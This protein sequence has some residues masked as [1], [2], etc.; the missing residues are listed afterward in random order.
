MESGAIGGACDLHWC[1]RIEWDE[2]SD[3]GLVL[4]HVLGGTVTP[5]DLGGGRSQI[6]DLDLNLPDGRS[7]AVEV[8]RH[9]SE[10]YQARHG[11]AER[12]EWHFADLR[13]DWHVGMVQ[14]F[15]V[16]DINRYLPGLLRR[17]EQEE[18]EAVLVPRELKD[19]PSE[20]LEELHALG[21]RITYRLG[22]ADQRGGQIYLGEAP[23]AGVTAA[24][25]VVDVASSH[26][27]LADNQAKLKAATDADERHLFI[28]VGA[29]STQ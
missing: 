5:R 13:F 28:W 6:H 16:Q 20:L 17:L 11:A 15:L 24:D 29:I 8:T 22:S 18:R 23:V 25:L 9:T 3:A 26:A 19:D 1:V 7:V 10:A 21:V 27:A 2:E 12:M 14:H 4:R